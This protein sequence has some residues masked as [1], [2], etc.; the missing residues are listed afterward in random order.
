[1]PLKVS[2]QPGHLQ[3]TVESDLLDDKIALELDQELKK[4]TEKIP[5][6]VFDLST[7]KEIYPQALRTIARS[8]STL[9]QNDVKSAFLVQ[10]SVFKFVSQS[11]MDRMIRCFE[12]IQEI[13]PRAT[14][15][16]DENHRTLE[17]LNTALD[18]AV[19]TFKVATNTVV[20]HQK[21]YLRNES[22]QPLQYDVAAMVGLVSAHFRGTLVLAFPAKTYL[23]IMNRLTGG[24]STELQ[25]ETRDGVA[26]LLNI[27][28]GQA[29][30]N[31]NQKGFQIK[32]AIPT[33]IE[34]GKFHSAESSATRS[35][36]I[37]F[38]SDTGDFF[39]E[40]TTDTQIPH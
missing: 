23:P 11:G 37:P 34:G 40:L 10:P 20:T 35:L 22:P 17:F 25:E 6:I 38:T 31:L 36:I 4:Q 15:S 32:Q 9:S 7:V 27:I 21:P 24:N 14:A 39:I 3:I 16:T 13:V 2:V 29:K 28:L 1:M 26:E 30:A 8:L 12:S 5:M 33:L 19:Y 18:A